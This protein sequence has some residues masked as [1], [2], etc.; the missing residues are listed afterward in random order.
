MDVYLPISRPKYMYFAEEHGQYCQL[1]ELPFTISSLVQQS[2]VL[3]YSLGACSIGP[4]RPANNDLKI[5][6][7]A[8]FVKLLA[9]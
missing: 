9:T 1:T 3:D 7:A 8:V 2:N 4:L 6:G 5:T